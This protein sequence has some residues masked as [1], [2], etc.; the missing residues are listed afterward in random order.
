MKST[1]KESNCYFG[2]KAHVSTDQKTKLIKKVS[3]SQNKRNKERG[4]DE[5][6]K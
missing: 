3:T 6:R 2:A 4:S 1:K 5:F